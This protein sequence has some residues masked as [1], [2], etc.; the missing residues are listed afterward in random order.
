MTLKRKDGRWSIKKLIG[1]ATLGAS[2]ITC[3]SLFP[4]AFGACQ[5]AVSPWTS[6]PENV[7]RIQADVNQI[8]IQIS[9]KSDTYTTNKPMERTGE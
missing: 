3:I 9:L 6:L 2:I 5:K 4:S 7:A 1:I 8:K